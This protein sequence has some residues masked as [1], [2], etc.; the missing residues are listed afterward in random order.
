MDNMAY[1]TIACKRTQHSILRKETARRRCFRSVDP[2]SE[3]SSTL[4]TID[5]EPDHEIVHRRRFGKTNGAAH[6][7]LDPCP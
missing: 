3:E 1:N 7:P 6:E 4:I 2:L 5:E